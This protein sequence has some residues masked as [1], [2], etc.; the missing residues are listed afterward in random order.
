MAYLSPSIIS[1]M[2]LLSMMLTMLLRCLL[3]LPF[4][5]GALTQ[6]GP[7]SLTRSS[8]K[9]G[10]MCIMGWSVTRTIHSLLTENTTA[11]Y[12]GGIT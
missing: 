2:L 10:T 9:L 4:R 12:P 5:T 3:L 7:S 1:N 11:E 8:G 6:V